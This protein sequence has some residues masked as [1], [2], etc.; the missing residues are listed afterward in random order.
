MKR[1]L[2][3][4]IILIILLGGLLV[5]AISWW[6]TNSKP[7]SSS[8][9]PVRLVIPKGSS[10]TEIGERLQDE[11]LIKNSLAFKIYVQFAN[12]AK[13]I[14]AG[15]Y[16]LSPNLSLVE[17]VT[18]L[19]SGPDE[20]WVTI[21][22][23]L[24]REEVVE[25]FI[26]GLEIQEDT[27]SFR[28]EFLSESAGK[29]GFLFPD[30]YL[31]PKTTKASLVVSKMLSTFN[32]KLDDGLQ[33]RINESGYSL[34]EI[35]ILASIVERETGGDAE[36]PLVAGILLKRLEAG[37]SLQ[38]DAALQ[39]AVANSKLKTQNSKLD[40]WWPVLTREDLEID[41]A[42]NTYKFAGLPPAPIASPGLSSIKAVVY[43]EES[44]YWFY[45]HDGEGNVHFAET[46]EEHNEN[47]RMYLGK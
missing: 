24:R 35:V 14:Q 31:F 12:K 7:A 1:L 6:N 17:I 32:E 3:A 18:K 9:T 13:K 20:V 2:V 39:Y 10:A 25:K 47:I 16:T 29:E 27:E 21:P 46:L 45:L 41:S 8:E 11:D 33:E 42:F 15:E 44:P 19:S 22:E 5:G 30:T 4:I 34:L 43:P 40:N 38:A 26:A 37:W 36:R 28:Q 23:G